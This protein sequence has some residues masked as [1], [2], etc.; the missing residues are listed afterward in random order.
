MCFLLL[1]I[2]LFTIDTFH[3]FAHDRK[4]AF[5]IHSRK[6][7]NEILQ[8]TFLAPSGVDVDLIAL[9]VSYELFQYELNNEIRL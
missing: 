7:L 5:S 2:K 6:S 8:R 9:L 1:H 4:P 3:E